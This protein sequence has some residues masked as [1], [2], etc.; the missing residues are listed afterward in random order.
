MTYLLDTDSLSLLQQGHPKLVHE[1][2][3][4]PRGVVRKQVIVVKEQIDGRSIAIG[5][6]KTP[7]QFANAWGHYATAVAFFSRFPIVPMTVAAILRFHSLMKQKL[8]IGGNDLL[9]AAIALELG[10]AVVSRNLRDFSRMPGLTVV[11]WSA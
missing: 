9:I 8:N 5:R 4:H 6:A 2:D 3:A 7:E 1:V 10:V 11:D